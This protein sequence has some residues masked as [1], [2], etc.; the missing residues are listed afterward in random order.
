MQ[1]E[2]TLDFARN[3]DQTD[4][5]A[6]FRDE[7]IIPKNEKGEPWTYLCGNSL[8]LQPVAA[9][10]FLQTELNDWAALGVEGHF[11]GKNPW[12]HYHKFLTDHSAELV[13]GLPHEV[14]VMNQ[15][16]VNLHLLFASFYRPSS[17][18]Y[19]IIME[20]G[21]FPS[22]MYAV[23]SQVEWHGFN[24]DNAVIEMQPRAGEHT[25][26][27]ADILDTI[28][29]NRDSVA[30]VFFSGV[31]YYT[32]QYF[33][34]RAITE[35]AHE[36]QAFA[37]FDLAHAAG[38][39]ALKLHEW[40]VDFAS[41]C[42]YKYLNS[43][44]GNVSG[45]FVHEKHGLNAQTPR[46]AGWW[47]HKE[48]VRFQMKRGYIP[49]PGAAGW[50]LSNAPVFGMA[51]HR[52]SLDIFHRAGI[53]RLTAKSALL[54]AYLRFVLSQAKISNPHLLFEIITPEN[55]E[56]CQLSL[57]AGNNGKALFDHLTACNVIA[58]WREPNVI[59]MAPVPLYN[60]FTDAW[61]TGEAFA[62][63]NPS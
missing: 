29:Q 31:Q 56:G 34:I 9:A 23:Q 32:G 5:L 2:N 18:R 15:L 61:K 44:P 8:G 6:P 30:L 7:F 50:Q 25:L 42:S 35:A 40:N 58:D 33:D 48:D 38:N 28:H 19:K 51:V 1:F 47:G 37:G 17:S 62:S 11:H 52:A 4:P 55:Q 45:V 13:G 3:Q 53:D 16:T 49:E 24:Y 27:T 21:A 12:F 46:L 60:S 36:A 22:D 54:T 39:V 43:G 14:V 26:R 20:A 63:F 41:W 10:E 59:R 57:L